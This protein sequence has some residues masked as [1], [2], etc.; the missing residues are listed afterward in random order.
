M[1]ALH[2]I[3]A[4]L[5]ARRLDRE[6]DE[7]IATHLALQEAEFRRAGMSA[8]AARDAALREFGGVAHTKEVYRERRGLPWLETAAKD[9]QYAW[10]G[11]RQNKGFAAAAV[12]S[13]AL[14]MGANTA[15]FT[16]F[17]ALMLRMLPV[18]RPS[19]LVMLNRTGAW[20]RACSYPFYLELQK[21]TDLFQGVVARSDIQ[22]VRF[23]AERAR[24]EFVSGNYFEVLGVGA[25]VGRLIGPA[26]NTT[27]HAH[28]VAVLS[29]NF[30]RARFAADPGAVGRTIT[31][32]DEPLTVV[33]VAARGFRG[34]E[35]DHEPDL[36]APAM[37][38]PGE[39]LEPGSN[40]AWIVARRRPEINRTQVQAAIDVAF[41]QYL[42]GVYGSHANAGF[43]R[44]AMA[45]QIE[46][47]DAG[48][49][50]SE[51]REQFATPLKALMA[52]VGL[53][54][55]AACT[56]VANL[57]L[58]R[59]AARRKEIAMRL[60]LGATRGRLIG[61]ALM[62]SLLLASI[63]A[64][65]GT[66]LAF[67]GA[68]AIVRFL[69]PG[70]ADALAITP[71]GA[72]LG[73][74]AAISLAAVVVLGLLPALRSSS[75]D[76]A[77]SLQ[78]GERHTRGPARLRRVLV[79]V[80]VAFSVVLVALA[81]LF[82]HSMAQLRSVSLGFRNADAVTFS[83]E[84][85]RAW[86]A[87][88]TKAARERVVAQVEAL[89]GV[90]IVTAAFPA[91]F[92]GGY[93][94]G[95]VRV[96]GSEAT[97]KEPAWV[98]VQAVGP[99]YFEA[100]RG[101]MASGR[102]FDRNDTGQSRSVAVVNE[103]FVRHF[104]PGETRILEHVIEKGVAPTFIV[105]VVR[106]V[107]SDDLRQPPVPTVYIPTAQSNSQPSMV[108]T[109]TV[110]VV[111]L[112]PAIRRELARLG[113]QVAISEPRTIR[114]RID[115]SM[116]QDRLLAALGGVFGLLALAL[117]AVGLYGVVAYGTARR[118]REIGIRIALGARRGEVV[119]MVLSDAL[120]LVIAGLAVGLPA[121]YVAAKQVGALLFGVRPMDLVTFAQT[122]VVLAT[123]GVAAALLPARKAAGLEPLKVLRQD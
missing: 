21:R 11:L 102:E 15:I 23:G 97:L 48:I 84:F 116:F 69:P 114:Q 94:S 19:E 104:L 51:L 89:P 24:R 60:S 33:G 107:A 106:D 118:A 67:W 38:R 66:A 80:Q 56:N 55:L 68:P 29:Y 98:N 85:P 1:G 120:V 46:V 72:V 65:L 32:N 86:K 119:W 111:S 34:V 28:P 64:A 22:R 5:R 83:L 71:D 100:L 42:A 53:V 27:A 74:A 79:T 8:R 123:I 117:A 36:W 20:G 26:D 92:T 57:L 7:E 10:R 77:L 25:T 40:W 31:I 99:R 2:R 14:G 70:A 6:L 112:V 122:A 12:L 54:L 62:E 93:S 35:V 9:L 113:P 75:V 49:G 78:S 47:R 110:P 58:A 17:R 90:S 73:F 50:L 121:S 41:R 82:G 59:G 108:V 4:L 52:A 76:P 81:V 103:A 105:G 43:R 13:L 37:M 115:D 61:Q 45:Q 18:E 44:T 30:W 101:S 91:P 39:I 16:I 63:G 3:W 96:P 109:G 88:Q 95:T 87:D